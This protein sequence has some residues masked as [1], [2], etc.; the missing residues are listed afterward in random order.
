MSLNGDF[1]D[2]LHFIAYLGEI[3]KGFYN[4]YQLNDNEEDYSFI[5]DNNSKQK[6]F[7]KLLN[8]THIRFYLSEIF[9]NSPQINY[10][11]AIYLSS[12][13]TEKCVFFN[14]YYLKKISDTDT[15][16]Y[17]F[18]NNDLKKNSDE[19]GYNYYIDL[20]YPKKFDFKKINQILKI[21]LMGVTGPKYN[22][23]KIYDSYNAY[24]CYDTCST[25]SYIG[26]K[27]QQ[28]C[29]TCIEGKVFVKEKGNCLDK[30]PRGYYEE[31]KICKKCYGNCDRRYGKGNKDNNNCL[32][33]DLASNNK[34]LVNVPEL[35]KNCVSECPEDTVLKKMECIK[36]EFT[37]SNIVITFGVV[38]GAIILIILIIV[39]VKLN[40]ILSSTKN[41]TV[42]KE[43]DTKTP[44]CIQ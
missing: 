3:S 34:Y 37:N 44:L 1:G 13:S 4:Y 32:S 11:F 39:F 8:K 36:K 23:V 16:I 29:N 5:E 27:D 24:I 15:E 21:R 28:N 22:Y 19:A 6:Y 10:I 2:Y 31:D 20:P 35:G 12:K 17:N 33:C 30:C 38:G 43:M 9:S 18:N 40:T 26:T 14:N 7:F 25:C 42:M 41:A